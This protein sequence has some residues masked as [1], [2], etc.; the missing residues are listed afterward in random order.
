MRNLSLLRSLAPSTRS[1][2]VSQTRSSAIRLPSSTIRSYATQQNN[3]KPTPSGKQHPGQKPTGLEGLF[4]DPA[5]TPAGTGPGAPAGPDLRPPTLPGTES[6]S[7]PYPGKRPDVGL[8]GEAES[9]EG[10]TF[11]ERRKKLSDSTGQGVKAA[12][13][14]GGGGGSGGSGGPGGGLPGGGFGLTPNQLMWAIIG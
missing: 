6:P 11:K 9:E 8:P 1:R 10:P 7:E 13:G 5:P 2:L 12:F 4:G 3:A 14:G